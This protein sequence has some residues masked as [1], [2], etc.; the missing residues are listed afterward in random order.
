PHPAER[1]REIFKDS[2]YTH[3]LVHSTVP[4]MRGVIDTEL[5]AGSSH[6]LERD[7]KGGWT[8]V[9]SWKVR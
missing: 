8:V 5:P 4:T 6:L 7:S 1:F 9:R 2:G 3:I